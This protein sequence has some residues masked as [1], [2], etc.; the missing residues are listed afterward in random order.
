MYGYHSQTE[1]NLKKDLLQAIDF[2][3]KHISCYQLTFENGTPFHKKLLSK[4][5]TEF[6]E[7]KFIKQ[8]E[9]IE[10]ILE[11]H[12][13]RRYEISNYAVKGFESKHNL[14]YWKYDDYLGI[15]P[16]AHSRITENGRKN[17]IIKIDD[18]INWRRSLNK[19]SIAVYQKKVLTET[20]NLE[21]AIIMGLR[22][23]DGLKFQD[24]YR[25]ISKETIDKNITY[26]KLQ[27]LRKQKLIEDNVEKIKLTK[28]GLAKVN[29]IAEFLL[30]NA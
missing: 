16:G 13:I 29:S 25:K 28:T 2:G 24:L 30:A 1:V 27:F 15:G 9:L 8:Y 17:E 12:N 5:I 4:E 3:C 23:V 6:N 18:P 19:N 14:S 26:A 7:K 22:L 20:E 11:M 10:S 21:E